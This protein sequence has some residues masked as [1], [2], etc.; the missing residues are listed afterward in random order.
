[1]EEATQA[2]TSIDRAEVLLCN[3]L[4]LSIQSN[5]ERGPIRIPTLDIIVSLETAVS[6]LREAQESI[7]MLSSD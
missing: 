3:L 5:G 6:L 1:M 7:S 4:A 2:I